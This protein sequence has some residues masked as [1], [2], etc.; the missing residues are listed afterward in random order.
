MT[1][2]EV[3]QVLIEQHPTQFTLDRR[4]DE[5]RELPLPDPLPYRLSGTFRQ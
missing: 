5:G 3:S 1:M 4:C 2:L